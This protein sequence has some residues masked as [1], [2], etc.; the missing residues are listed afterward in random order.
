MLRLI[1]VRHGQTDANLNKL[2]QGQSDGQLNATGIQQAEEVGLH[3]KDIQIDQVISSTLSR[4][5]DTA[6]AIAQ[7]HNL[8]VIMTP[9]IVEWNCGSLDGIPAEAFHK[10]MRESHSTISNFHPDGGET[11]M[12][13]RRRAQK[14][15]ADVTAKY[16][17]QTVL[18]C[19]H[20]DFLRTVISIFLNIT[21]EEAS[22]IQLDNASYSIFELDN[23]KWN[24][25]KLN[26]SAHSNLTIV[27]SRKSH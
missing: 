13:V 5:R 22:G 20:G 26:Q 24:L 11:V 12:D 9:L 4:A 16:Q 18:V 10:K 15:I 21:A 3:L 27:D 19:S 14:F 7:Y 23:G 2:I 6:A 25:V 8:P 1:L 17:D